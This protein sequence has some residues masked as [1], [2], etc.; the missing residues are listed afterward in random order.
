MHS[1][2]FKTK[3]QSYPVKVR[4][5]EPSD[6]QNNNLNITLV[7]MTAIGVPLRKYR[8]FIDALTQKGFTV[9]SADYPCCGENRPHIKRGVD[10]G[11]RDLVVS[12]IPKL[13]DI[14]KQTTPDNQIILFGHSLGAHIAS[15][16]CAT[17]DF[18]MVGVATGNIH[19]KNWKGFGKIKI[20]AAIVTFELL[21][22]V[23][24]YLPGYKVGFGHREAKTLMK[25]WLHTAK[26]GRYDFMRKSLNTGLGR[27]LFIN[28]VG[29][30]FAPYK[31]TKRLSKLC[32]DSQLNKVKI[33]PS[34]KGNPHSAWLKSPN[35]IIDEVYKNL[36]FFVD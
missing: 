11:Y 15:L 26:T 36:D 20:L 22:R 29:D 33:D 18:A 9:V 13:I 32:A 10:Y 3:K 8:T 31:S 14:A 6:S 17:T 23:Y 25:D 4:I 5:N 16:Y 7:L 30:D 34:L 24:G 1:F 12:F 21:I 2:N 19:Y 27:G 35:E 28:I